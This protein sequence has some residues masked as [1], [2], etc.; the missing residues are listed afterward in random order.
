VVNDSWWEDRG[1]Y[2]L[3]KGSQ[4]EREYVEEV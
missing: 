2:F 1:Y 3:R 4:A